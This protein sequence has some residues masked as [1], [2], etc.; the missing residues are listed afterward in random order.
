ME[1]GK[2]FKEN[3]EHSKNEANNDADEYNE[4]Y[5][6]SGDEDSM[7]ELGQIAVLGS[8]KISLRYRSSHDL[9][10]SRN[11]GLNKPQDV[12]S[13]FLL[14]KSGLSIKDGKLAK[15][16]QLDVNESFNKVEIQKPAS[17]SL[18]PFRGYIL[19]IFSAFVFCLSQ[20]IIKR[21]KTLSASDHSTIRYF[22]TFVIMITYLKYR[23]MSILGPRKQLKLL[24]FRGFIGK[25]KKI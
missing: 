2:L 22:T 24:L 4:D 19:G 17:N 7:I 1:S 14:N 10:L 3:E 12:S 20:V 15:E 11:D 23:N 5:R 8:S 9:H 18:L 25:K 16:T 21:A 6:D 13:R